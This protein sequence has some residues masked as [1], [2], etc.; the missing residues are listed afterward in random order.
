MFDAGA[1]QLA[2]LVDTLFFPEL[3]SWY[4]GTTT[5]VMNV[6]RLEP[7]ESGEVQHL[8]LDDVR[9]LISKIKSRLTVMTHLGITMLRAKPWKLA[10]QLTQELGTTVLAAT[11]GKIVEVL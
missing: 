6:V 7:H 11:D 1:A 9:H 5:L 3:L 8:C 2:F 10:E 4:Q